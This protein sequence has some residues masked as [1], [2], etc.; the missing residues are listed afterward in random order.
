MFPLALRTGSFCLAMISAQF[1]LAQAPV[2]DSLSQLLA[3]AETDTATARLLIAVSVEWYY[4]DADSAFQYAA[5]G[6]ALS[7]TI[8]FEE[9]MARG[10]NAKGNAFRKMGELDSALQ[11]YLQALEIRRVQN[12]ARSLAATLNNL[13]QV[14]RRMGNSD[15]AMAYYQEGIALVKDLPP[16]REY[17]NLC[18]SMGVL[19]KRQEAWE[20]AEAWLEKAAEIA[21]LRKDAPRLAYAQSNLGILAAQQGE[22]S[23]AMAY[24][25]EAMELYES[26]GNASATSRTLRNMGNVMLEQGLL[27]QAEPLYLKSLEWE[28]QTS[29]PAA[30]AHAYLNLGVLFSEY[31]S[32][33]KAL[34]FFHRAEQQLDALPFPEL[35]Q[36]IRLNLTKTYEELGQ[37]EQASEHLQQYLLLQEALV[38]RERRADSLYQSLQLSDA[39]RKTAQANNRLLLAGLLLLLILI[40][41]ALLVANHRRRNQKLAQELIGVL[42]NQEVLQLGAMLKG[43][44]QAQSQLAKELHDNIGMLL[45]ATN[46]HFSNVAEKLTSQEAA[47]MQAQQTLQTAVKEV[48]RMS[49]EMVSGTMKHL[50]LIEAL[51]ELVAA[52]GTDQLSIGFESES[53]E[54][55]SLPHSVSLGLYR[56]IQELISNAI[57]H[58]EAGQLSIQ[59]Q[60]RKKEWVIMV[61]DD[62]KGFD[63]DQALDS[64]GMG[65]QNATARMREMGGNFHLFSQKGKG[66]T[67]VLTVPLID[68]KESWLTENDVQP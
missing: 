17:G 47:F 2:L 36:H 19:L 30:M 34:L 67:V 42:R 52:V 49:H 22:Y 57:R 37:S 58:A 24:L 5:E 12:Q 29:D 66:T 18:N 35:R 14:S 16:S 64:H 9:G 27:E 54:E 51:E 48:R 28:A 23:E 33:E 7:R 25:M 38:E 39:E 32:Y 3:N 44:E 62:G 11:C 53:R 59:L 65:L 43:Q 50:G 61:Q 13:G 10:W 26:L 60:Q 1:M 31:E 40:S 41:G 56:V 46:L 63:P 55:P 4:Q 8:Q 15:E 21:R 45:S 6:L 68:W 20:E